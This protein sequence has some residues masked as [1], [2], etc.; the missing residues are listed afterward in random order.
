MDGTVVI[1]L[2]DPDQQ[3]VDPAAQGSIGL[4]GEPAGKRDGSASPPTQGHMTML[5]AG[6]CYR[7]HC[8]GVGVILLQTIEGPDTI[9]RWAEICQTD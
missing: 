2:L 1:E 3:L 4:D 9:Y 8:D 5:P 6:K 7:F